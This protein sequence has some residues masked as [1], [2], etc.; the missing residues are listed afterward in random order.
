MRRPNPSLVTAIAVTSIVLSGCA[1]AGSSPTLAPPDATATV[2]P[3]EPLASATAAPSATSAPSVEPSG[4]LAVVDGDLVAGAYASTSL[5]LDMSF[6]LEAGWHGFA[7]IEDVGFALSREG[8][9]GG[10][11]VTNFGGEVFSDPC[12]SETTEML[13]PTAEAFVAWLADHP[14]LD[15][16]EPVDVTLGGQSGPADR[17]DVR[18]RGRVPRVPQDLA[19]GPA[20]RR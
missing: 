6:D 9:G 4:P 2:A 17:P 13:A 7:D 11:S 14:E 1:A 10:V 3:T 15:A 20:G 5:G 18:R 19:L 16:S 8:I 12:S